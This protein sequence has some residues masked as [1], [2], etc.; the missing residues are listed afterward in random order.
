L[1]KEKHDAGRCC[2]TRLWRD[3]MDGGIGK[4]YRN[5][6]WCHCS[7]PGCPARRASSD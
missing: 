6:L 1:S 2:S 3:Q 7:S 4:I 5:H